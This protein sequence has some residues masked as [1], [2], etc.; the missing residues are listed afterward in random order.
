MKKPHFYKEG[1]DAKKQLEQLKEFYKTTPEHVRPWV[2]QEIK[3]LS[4]GIAGEENVKFELENSHIPMIVLHDLHLEY[5][6]LS[7][8]VD[9]MIITTKLILIVE[10]KNLYGHI[11]VDNRG[12]F[13]RS[14]EFN[15]RFKKE[16]IY[17]PITQNERHLEL[18]KKIRLQS[19]NNILTRSIFEKH[20]ED[21]YKSVVVLANP[22]TVINTKY[23]KKKIR[24][25][26]IRCDQLV[27]YIKELVKSS[28]NEV[29]LEKIMYER[30]DFFLSFHTPNTTDYTK[31][32]LA[33]ENYKVE[34]KAEKP[35]IPVEDTPLY[36]ELRQYRY[37]ASKAGGL[38][39]YMVYN[40]AEMEALISAM[41]KT[42]KDLKKISGFGE[43]KC[44][45]YGHAILE[46]INK[47]KS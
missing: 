42:L 3:M 44:E 36:K 23:A 13:I 46:I 5:D 32:F 2:E 40:N 31:K 27:G 25:Q 6:G 12:N 37:E 41:P 1:I 22:K 30:A 47:H 19:K 15:G 16:G 29:S 39:P 20:F 45:R 8:Q 10:C 4:Y 24:D 11:E 26:I 43:V 7:A 28:K 34:T 17:S 35:T 38:K 21:N 18:I 33:A 9:Y 14:F